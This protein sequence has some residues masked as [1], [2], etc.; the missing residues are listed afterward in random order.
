MRFM[1][2]FDGRYRG[3]GL[4]DVLSAG[5]LFRA[6]Q[7]D[8]RLAVLGNDGGG[9]LA[10][11]APADILTIDY[12]AMMHDVLSDRHDPVVNLMTR[13]TRKYIKR[14]IVAGR[15]I[16]KNGQCVSVDLPGLESELNGQARA[17]WALLPPDDQATAQMRRAVRRY[18]GCGCHMGNGLTAA[19]A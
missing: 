5:R 13:A 2:F 12:G 8:G 15:V 11:G 19:F 1:L 10:A 14:L 16:V 6:A 4:D 18:Y 3:F 17:A 9:L 7:I